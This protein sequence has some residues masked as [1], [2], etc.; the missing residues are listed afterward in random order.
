MRLLMTTDTVGG[1]WTFTK[2][3]IGQ[4]LTC[5]CE[6]V[7]VSFGRAPSA[8]QQSAM[9]AL[10]W[11]S[12]H[13]F[14]YVP[15]EFPLEWMPENADAYSAG[16]SLLLQLAAS[17]QPDGLLLSQFCFGA[18]PVTAPKIVVAHSDVMSWAAA[19]GRAPLPNDAWLTT[20]QQLVQAGLLGADCVVAPTCA[21]L[22]DLRAHFQIAC[23]TAVIPNGRTLN[24]PDSARP[25]ELRAAAAGR[26]WD[27]AKNL[28]LLLAIQ[29]PVPIQVAGDHDGVAST[30]SVTLLGRQT[31]DD[32]LDL[33]RCSAIYL[34]TSGYEPFGLAPLEAAMCGCAVVAN[35]IPSLREVWGEGALFFQDAASLAG[36]L[37]QLRG[38]PQALAQAQRRSAERARLYSAE[39]MAANYLRQVRA[40]IA[41]SR[42]VTHAA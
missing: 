42:S 24:A 19:V 30:E 29:S 11:G 12:R 33:F 13:R 6:I 40:A 1:V 41:P 39:T 14:R 17:F 21:M 37:H 31:E 18:L 3:L 32:L 7:L 4:L 9:D 35:D 25:R 5:E 15:T 36:L 34:C 16:A 38:D 2:E 26:M 22:S 27:E 8:D 20:Y 10:T 28:S 23:P